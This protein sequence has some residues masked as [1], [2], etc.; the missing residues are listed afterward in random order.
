[1]KTVLLGAGASAATLGDDIAPISANFGKTLN[2]KIPAWQKTHYPFLQSAVAYLQKQQS[3]V[4]EDAWPLDAVWNGIDENNKLGIT[5]GDIEVVEN[6]HGEGRI[7]FVPMTRFHGVRRTIVWLVLEG[8]AF[9]LNAPSK[10]VTPGLPWPRE[11]PSG[12]WERTGLSPYNAT[13][14]LESVWLDYEAT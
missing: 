3:N 12:L 14:A 11:A 8:Q 5:D 13:E 1:M 4:S 10:L 7:A 6:P 2:D 9:A